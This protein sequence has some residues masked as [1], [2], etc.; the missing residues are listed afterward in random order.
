[1][2]SPCPIS[3]RGIDS[4]CAPQ[5]PLALGAATGAA[6]DLE[7]PGRRLEPLLWSSEIP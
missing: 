4:E 1:M 6:G 7:R 2:A 3:E 5:Q